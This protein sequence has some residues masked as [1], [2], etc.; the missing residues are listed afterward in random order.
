[1]AHPARERGHKQRTVGPPQPR[2][3]QEGQRPD[4]HHHQPER[5][6]RCVRRFPAAPPPSREGGASHPVR[7]RCG[8]GSAP[9][10]QRHPGPRWMGSGSPRGEDTKPPCQ[11]CVPAMRRQTPPSQRGAPPGGTPFPHPA[12]SHQPRE[13]HGVSP[14]PGR[15]VASPG[16][17]ITVRP[18]RWRRVN[19][20]PGTGE[21]R[22]VPQRHC[23][24]SARS[25]FP[26]F[27]I[28]SPS[29]CMSASACTAKGL[30]HLHQGGPIPDDLPVLL[31]FR[32]LPATAVNRG[33]E[34]R[35]SV[36]WCPPGETGEVDAGGGAGRYARPWASAK[37][38]E[39]H[40]PTAPTRHA[41]SPEGGRC[42]G[43]R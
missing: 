30:V 39:G 22:G 23:T 21:R 42:P 40:Q 19:Q 5:R 37:S 43:G 25:L 34:E 31:V 15:G 3:S 16:G 41:F 18:W 32:G 38:L 13:R 24:P 10:C 17:G 14:R 35:P 1:M 6:R 2:Q 26:R 33:E 9:G 11:S 28:P 7:S 29:A 36:S 27:R 12:R 8:K 4:Q 20:D